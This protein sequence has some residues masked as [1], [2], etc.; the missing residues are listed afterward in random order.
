MF[1]SKRISAGRFP[2]VAARAADTIIADNSRKV[3]MSKHRLAVLPETT[4]AAESEETFRQKGEHIKPVELRECTSLV[5]IAFSGSRV[6]RRGGPKYCGPRS[7]TKMWGVGACLSQWGKQKPDT[8]KITRRFIIATSISFHPP[9]SFII[10]DYRGLLYRHARSC[11]AL[12]AP[13]HFGRVKL[14]YCL[15]GGGGEGDEAF[16]LRKPRPLCIAD[17]SLFNVEL[18]RGEIRSE[19]GPGPHRD[20]AE[21]GVLVQMGGATG[22]N[23]KQK[24]WLLEKVSKLFESLLA[25]IGPDGRAGNLLRPSYRLSPGTSLILF[26]IFCVLL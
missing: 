24:V 19:C 15:E 16:K 20:G 12:T 11:S 3:S 1:E 7:K 13:L 9:T 6:R 14:N 17:F 21:A 4:M 26:T 25:F 5:K 10:I 8:H 2:A 23:S 22:E 18:S